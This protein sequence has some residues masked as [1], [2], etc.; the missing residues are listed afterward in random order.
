MKRFRLTLSRDITQLGTVFIDAHTQRE[1]TG[2]LDNM[3]MHYMAHAVWDPIGDVPNH[4]YPKLEDIEEA[5]DD[6]NSR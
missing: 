2:I 5:S 3:P 4:R 1:A 6:D